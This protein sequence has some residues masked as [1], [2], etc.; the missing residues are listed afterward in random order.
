MQRNKSGTARMMDKNLFAFFRTPKI[1]Y[2]HKIPSS[3]CRSVA[4]NLQG[5][6]MHCWLQTF[7]EQTDLY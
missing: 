1:I 3:I 2:S 6:A 4:Q 7:V 5:P